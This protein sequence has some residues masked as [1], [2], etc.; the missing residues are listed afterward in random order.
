MTTLSPKRGSLSV[1]VRTFKAAVT[2]WARNNGCEAFEWQGRFYD[3]IIRNEADLHRIRT[4]IANNPV[5]WACD[6]ENPDR[7]RMTN[8]HLTRS[9]F[10]TKRH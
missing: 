9:A 6:Q 7:S 1:V 4:Y 10:F 2:T 3:H 5:R 8:A